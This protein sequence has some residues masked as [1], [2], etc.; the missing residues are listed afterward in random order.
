MPLPTYPNITVGKITPSTTPSPTTYLPT[1]NLAASFPQY[2]NRG[3]IQSWNYFIQREL[4]SNLTA[5]VGYVG[6]HAV[7]QMM[8]VNIN[9]AA[10]NTGTAGRQL[11][12]YLQTDFNTYEPF[13]DMTYNALQTDVKKRIGASIIG[14]AY[15][16]SKAIDNY[17]GDNGDATLFRAYPV[18]YSLD[19]ALAGFDRTHVFQ[20][21][22][23][24]QLPFG[25]GH[26]YLNQGLIAQIVG[27]FQIGGTLSRFSGLPFTISSNNSVNAPGQSQSANQ[28]SPD[29]QILGGHDP[30]T[31]YFSGV[32]FANPAVGTLGSTGRDLLRGP[33]L[34]N[35]DA[36]IS[37]S[38]TFKGEKIKLQIVGEAFNLTNTPSFST[39]NATFASPTVNA[40][41]AI[42]SYGNYSVIT[43]TVSTQ[44]QLQVSAYLRF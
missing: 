19:K 5:E 29:V 2:M 18:S 13:G 7:H 35:M 43:G 26:E 14:A 33:G 15:T 37:R 31:P 23:V 38:F 44:R 28:I 36:N 24:Y 21:Y 17:N 9:G 22:Y 11:Y 1:T 34:F 27:G 20:L 25:K 42:T 41:G 32:A 3:Y 30:N 12:P 10:P 4:S 16:F 39:P 40:A 6:T 8:G